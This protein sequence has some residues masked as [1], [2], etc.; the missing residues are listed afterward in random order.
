MRLPTCVLLLLA[1]VSTASAQTPSGST[2]VLTILGGAASGHALW[3]VPRQPLAVPGASGQFDTLRLSREVTS[4]IVVGASATYFF[5]PRLG[6]HAE[7]SYL[8]LPNDDGCTLVHQAPADSTRS[9]QIC[10]DIQSRSGSGGA[11]SLFVGATVR[12][13]ANR[14]LSPYLRGNIGLVTMPHS[15][16]E[17]AGNYFS[18]GPQ[19]VLVIGDPSPRHAAPLFGLAAGL[20]TPVGGDR[21]YQFRLEVRDV[22]TPIERV[23]GPADAASL[24]APTAS[25]L[26]HHLAL[27]IGLDV[28]LERKRG[29]RY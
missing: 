21:A 18:G 25:R 27:T 1:G 7:I 20:T 5:T 19:S 23:T 14:G 11:I 15:R 29:R 9:Q 16:V 24:L 10:N 6:V 22:I 26:Y 13:A 4:S 2:L 17:V 8:G 12:A 28:V 3:D